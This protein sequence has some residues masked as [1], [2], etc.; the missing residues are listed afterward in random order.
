MRH[1]EREDRAEEDKGRDWV[2][3][4]ERP[5]DTPITEHG[6]AQARA[7]AR[8]YQQQGLKVVKI[9]ASPLIRCVQTAH[10]VATLTGLTQIHVEQGLVEEAKSM[11]GYKHPEKRPNWSPLL[12]DPAALQ[13]RASPLVVVDHT[14][15]APVSHVR[16]ADIG[17]N[18]VLEVDPCDPGSRDVHKITR[19]RCERAARAIAEACLAEF[20][21][22]DED[23]AVLCVGHGAS[24]GGLARGLQLGLPKDVAMSAWGDRSSYTCFARFDVVAVDQRPPGGTAGGDGDDVCCVPGVRFHP[25]FDS[26]QSA[27]LSRLSG[28]GL[29]HWLRSGAEEPGKGRPEDAGGPGADA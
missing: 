20:A 11:R 18:E 1:A 17:Y 14:S 6:R 29:R 19:D 15:L 2:S 7:A 13:Q 21:D 27:H 3:G 4:A 24:I 8:E 9:L 16:D 26:W 5:H 10:E 23:V 28:D 25:A 12:L 22:H